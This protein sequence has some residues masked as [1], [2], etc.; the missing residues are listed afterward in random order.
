MTVKFLNTTMV[1]S[2]VILLTFVLNSVSCKDPELYDDLKNT[3]PSLSERMADKARWSWSD[4]STAN[5]NG[6]FDTLV[7][8]IDN[9]DFPIGYNTTKPSSVA[10][11]G[12]FLVILTGK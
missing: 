8:Q 11:L 4:L 7:F 6:L 9:F 3:E 10:I 2:T 5:L 12:H 1:L